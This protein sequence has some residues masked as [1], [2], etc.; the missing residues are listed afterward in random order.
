MIS[1]LSMINFGWTGQSK[2][3]KK[4]HYC[5]NYFRSRSNDTQSLSGVI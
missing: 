2:G 3:G 4:S 1:Q 5:W